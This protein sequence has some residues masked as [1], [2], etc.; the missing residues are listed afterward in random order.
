MFRARC[1]RGIGFGTVEKAGLAIGGGGTRGLGAFGSA[2]AAARGPSTFDVGLGTALAVR[3]SFKAGF[4]TGG[5]GTARLTFA[6]NAGT[7]VG[8]SVGP[9]SMLLLNVVLAGLFGGAG[10]A[11]PPKFGVANTTETR[12]SCSL[13]LTFAAGCRLT[14][15]VSAFLDG[16]KVL[17]RGG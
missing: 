9:L 14:D 8:G 1:E 7:G 11:L 5:G 4:D 13:S 2:R 10:T 6:T 16:G 12:T 15:V 17:A 3:T